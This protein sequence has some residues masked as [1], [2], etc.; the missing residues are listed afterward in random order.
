MSDPGQMAPDIELRTPAGRL[1]SL[2]AA[3]SLGP[4]LVTFF[5]VACPTCQ[6]LF[7]YLE[8]LNRAYGARGLTVLGISQDDAEATLEFGSAKGATFP[9]LLDPEPFGV[10]GSS[11][12]SNVPATFL[13]GKDGQVWE[14]L[15]GWSRSDVNSLADTIARMVGVT[16][17]AI[18]AEDDGA[19]AW[20]P[21]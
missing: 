14:T 3:W 12:I 21:G 17:S 2:R 1:V 18:S 6:L 4:V 11:G 8:K 5:K 10:S 16:P 9:L 7:P 19:P 15:S 13:V 20:K